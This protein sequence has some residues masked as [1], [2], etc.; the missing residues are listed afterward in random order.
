MNAA[1]SAARVA[2]W[3][4]IDSLTPAQESAWRQ[5]RSDEVDRAE[6]A[7]DG[8][9]LSTE[10]FDALDNHLIDRI[11][12]NQPSFDPTVYQQLVDDTETAAYARQI[13]LR[14]AAAKIVKSENTAN[15]AELPAA[16]TL[17]DVLQD[18]EEAARW[19]VEGLLP[20]GGNGILAAQFKAGKSTL[21]G[22]LLRSLVDG[23]PF[24]GKFPV[25]PVAPDVDGRPGTV[26]LIDTELNPSTNARWLRE[27]GIKN[28]DTVE[29]ISLRG[30]LS[31]FNI[32]DP[33]VRA[34]WRKQIEGAD[35]VILDCLRP[36]L[37]S[38]GLD[39]NLD[40]GQFLIAWDELLLDAAVY[41]S[42]IVQHMG[43]NSERARGSSRLLDWPDVTWKIVRADED[44]SSPRFFSAFGRDVEV[45]EGGLNYDAITRRLTFTDGNRRDG[46]AGIALPALIELLSEEKALSGRQ[47]EER[48][49]A[50]GH[51]QKA[52]R[53]ALKKA[54]EDGRTVTYTGAR[55]ATIH[56]LDARYDKSQNSLPDFA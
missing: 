16:R 31:T 56:S 13:R 2:V 55:R 41:E 10:T 4:R 54:H 3:Q 45:A 29:I 8:K 15:P 47:V 27:Q 46:A 18:P 28:T 21:V 35:V 6:A 53:A 23:D 39:E 12:N 9:S 1:A 19:R 50:K 25:Q 20:A 17:T 26:V 32:L 5:A 11:V 52:I 49:M 44:P 30:K 36:V 38:L 40:A 34:A 51:P 33:D 48:L 37:D 22:N 43:H 7:N 14:N 42:V 24:L